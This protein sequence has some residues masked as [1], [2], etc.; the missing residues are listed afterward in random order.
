MYCL[1]NNVTI[2]S[3]VVE[4]ISKDMEYVVSLVQQK[5]S[6]I[7]LY[8]GVTFISRKGVMKITAKNF[9]YMLHTWCITVKVPENWQ[10]VWYKQ[11]QLTHKYN[12]TNSS[13]VQ[14]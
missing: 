4:I 2:G 3:S 13:T 1:Y 12:T 14:C 10:H 11:S 6:H 8:F 9:K 7:Y 5:Q